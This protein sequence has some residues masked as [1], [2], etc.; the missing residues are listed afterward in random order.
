MRIQQ[1]ILLP[2]VQQ[3]LLSKRNPINLS[4]VFFPH[5]T[6][7]CEASFNPRNVSYNFLPGSQPFMAADIPLMA[8]GRD[9]IREHSKYYQGWPW[10]LGGPY[11]QKHC[12]VS[13]F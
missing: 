13:G 5:R 2:V 11:Y 8:F 1:I 7:W 12:V 6:I 3:G 4:A 9:E 10:G